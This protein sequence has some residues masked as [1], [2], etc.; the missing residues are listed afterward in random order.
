MVN[1]GKESEMKKILSVFLLLAVSASLFSCGVINK[2]TSD[3]GEYSGY[4][5]KVEYAGD[6]MPT[7]AEWGN[8]SSMRSTYKHTA[9][10]F[11]TY[12]VGLFLTYT[13]D[14][15]IKQKE[16]VLS[17]YSFFNEGDE[18]LESDCNAD[19]G[20]YSIQL[21]RQDYPYNTYKIGLL[22]GTDDEEGKICYL[23]YNDFDLDVLDNL[24]TY[25]RKYFYIV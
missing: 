24:D 3:I 12:T 1:A 23:F 20:G 4:L 16:K 17:E 13:E 11:D 19:V 14:E 15:Y 9:M 18:G 10:F 22:I 7:E 6:F 21:T 25:I 5:D 2:T 8:Y